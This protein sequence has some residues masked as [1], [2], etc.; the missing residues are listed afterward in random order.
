MKFEYE[1]PPTVQ[2]VQFILIYQS[3]LVFDIFCE[4]IF[5]FIGG[6]SPDDEIMKA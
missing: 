2:L 5:S 3:M 1:L 6:P 4:T